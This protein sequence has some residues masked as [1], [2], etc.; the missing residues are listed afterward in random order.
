MKL[1]ET[2]KTSFDH[3]I[4]EKFVYNIVKGVLIVL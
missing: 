3:L 4:R 1:M 2:I